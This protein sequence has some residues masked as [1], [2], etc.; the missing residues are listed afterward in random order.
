VSSDF[1]G[2]K[3]AG[4]RAPSGCWWPVLQS[5]GM[6]AV[7]WT[8]IGLLG[9]ALLES[10][11]SFFYLGTRIDALGAPLDAP[12][13]A[14]GP[15]ID[16]EDAA[17]RA[18]GRDL[19]SA[20]QAQSD[21]LDVQ[22]A[23]ILA[24]GRDVTAAILALGREQTAANQGSGCGAC[25]ADHRC[26][27]SPR[28]TMHLHECETRSELTRRGLVGGPLLAPASRRLPEARRGAARSILCRA[29]EKAGRPPTAAPVDRLMVLR[30]MPLLA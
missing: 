20:I 5:P 10:F 8:A 9:A 29:G 3:L 14:Q 28:G 24:Q 11:G 30:A 18:R 19:T 7:V 15:R 1:R 27:H 17:I 2:S 6:D 23:I 22:G 12:M 13:D 21:R 4:Y 16:G 26:G 25:C